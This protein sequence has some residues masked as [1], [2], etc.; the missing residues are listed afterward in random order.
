MDYEQIRY[1]VDGPI[2][3]ITLNRPDKLNA[4]TVRMMHEMIDAFDRADADDAVRVVIVTGAGRGFCAGA[5]SA[6]LDGL[7]GTGEYD[8][9]LRETPAEP[10]CA[11]PWRGST[12]RRCCWPPMTGSGPP[13]ARAR[14]SYSNR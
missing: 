7:A 5:D 13:R 14:P 6:A 4:F 1:D 8:S 10:G 3:T 2:L 9:G 11:Q 12:R